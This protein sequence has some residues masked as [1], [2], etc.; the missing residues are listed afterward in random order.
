MLSHTWVLAED[1]TGLRERLEDEHAAETDLWIYNDLAKAMAEAKQQNK[2]IFVTFRCIPC[3][4]CAGFDAEVAQGNE[5]VQKLAREKFVSVRQVEMKG[6][7]L[8]L[9]EF[10][11]DLNWAAVF[12]NAD[13][14]VYARYGTQSAEGADAYNS[15]D[16]LETTMRRVLELHA[17]YPGNADELA[18]KKP[19][20]KPYR[21]ALEMPGLENREKLAGATSR[22][23]CIHCHNIH[24]AQTAHLQ[25]TGAYTTDSL[26]R[27]PLPENIGLRLDP[28]NGR[29]I[30]TVLPDS[31]AAEAGL[32][33]GEE[34][35]H[36]G[37][38][39]LTSIADLQWVLHHLPITPTTLD[40]VGSKTGKATLSLPADWKRTD[41]TWRGSLWSVS[42]KMRVWMPQAPDKLREEYE[43]HADEGLYQVKWINRGSPAGKAAFDA[44][45]RENDLVVA[46]NGKPLPVDQLKFQLDLKLNYEVGQVL[47]LTILR[48]GQKREVR[49]PLVE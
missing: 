24:D 15:L 5:G 46:A 12:I 18:G 8:S 21:T 32:Q 44:G 43:M 9:F 33:V 49:V 28:V 35:T 26:W 10:D 29:K 40:V 36:A 30:E 39:A 31:P 19:K 25:K 27:Y 11:F 6:V 3:E 45:L 14:T 47:P 16:G 2:P 17:G 4:D 22:R 23:N 41:I 38:Q 7:D 20:A 13:G 42:P 34:I 1:P 37:G 48:N